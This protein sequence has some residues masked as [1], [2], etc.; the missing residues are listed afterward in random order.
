MQSTRVS[1]SH[2]VKVIP[3]AHTLP[4]P[5]ALK[6]EKRENSFQFK[7]QSGPKK[8][9]CL[10]SIV[11]IGVRPTCVC[12]SWLLSAVRLPPLDWTPVAFTLK[13]HSA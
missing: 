5:H 2:C 4:K 8:N 13:G 7:S 9:S 10:V 11:L 12:V 3:V 6:V 1:V